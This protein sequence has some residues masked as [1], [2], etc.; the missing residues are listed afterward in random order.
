MSQKKNNKYFKEMVTFKSKNKLRLTR[1]KT[2]NY[3]KFARVERKTIPILLC[4]IKFK[5][6]SHYL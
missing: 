5:P 6:Y 3:D 1:N 2:L 4:L